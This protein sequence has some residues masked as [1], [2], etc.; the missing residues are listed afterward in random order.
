MLREAY[1]APN[2]RALTVALDR[3]Q[4]RAGWPRY[5]L[6]CEAIRL[7]ICT[8]DH[9]RQWTAA[10]VAFVGEMAGKVSLKRIA[11]ELGRS[12]ESV[13]S[14]TEDLKLSRKIRDGYSVSDLAEML[15]VHRAKAEGWMR[16][17]LM[18]RMRE[19][20]GYRAS[21]NHVVAFLRRYRE[22]YDLRRVDQGWFTSVVFREGR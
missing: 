4:R 22:E 12:V 2:K 15:G 14:K 16:R 19:V 8:R 3:V 11:K 13:E 6:K 7:G 10:E 1:R 9:R 17:G 5:A 20:S 18:G 21:E